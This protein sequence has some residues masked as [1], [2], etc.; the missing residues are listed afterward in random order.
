MDKR[1]QHLALGLEL[2]QRELDRLVRGE[3]LAERLALEGVIDRLVDAVLRGA[4]ARGSLADPVLVEEV[5]HDTQ[6]AT[7]AAED[8]A[9]RYSDA[10][11]RDVR[12]VGRHVE[13]P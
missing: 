4:Q 13:R 9:V 8:R 2:D 10:R 11:E 12:V 1:A 7:L 3:W 5:L 6:P